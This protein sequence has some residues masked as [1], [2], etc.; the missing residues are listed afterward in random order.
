MGEF[1]WGIDRWIFQA[2]GKVLTVR[3][4]KAEALESAL[5]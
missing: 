1:D 5:G 3:A 2:V 4:I